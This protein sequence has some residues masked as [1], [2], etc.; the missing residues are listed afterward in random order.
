VG[1]WFPAAQS[2]SVQPASASPAKMAAQGGRQ[3][4][5]ALPCGRDRG[6]GWR[7]EIAGQDIDRA[8]PQ[9]AEPRGASL[10]ARPQGGDESR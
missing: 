6:G 3:A 5:H 9:G 1:W 2:F 4:V 10:E 8:A 7:G